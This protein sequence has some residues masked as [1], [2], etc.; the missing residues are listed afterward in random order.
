VTSKT[1]PCDACG[2][3]TRSPYGACR[4]T[5]ACRSRQTLNRLALAA[6]VCQVCDAP[7]NAECGVCKRT[8]ACLAERAWR[9]LGAQAQPCA[10]CGLATTDTYGACQRTPKCRLEWAKRYRLIAGDELRGQWQERYASDA[11][12][13]QKVNERN[14]AAREANP[15]RMREIGRKTR[16]RPIRPC[17]YAKAGC[18]EPCRPG[19]SACREHDNEDKQRQRERKRQRL[20]QQLADRQDGMCPW[21]SL[22]LLADLAAAH[23]DHVIPASRGGPDC[24]WNLQLLHPKCNRTKGDRLTPEALALASAHGINL[25]AA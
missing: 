14:Q 2:Q 21:C 11:E 5:P 3:P 1:V 4:R 25:L 7:T 15:E 10:I 18:M 6:K 22:P 17:R 12:F 16:A 9:L 13:R 20:Q 24:L 23:V 8:P 19:S